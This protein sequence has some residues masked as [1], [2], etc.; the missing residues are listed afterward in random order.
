MRFCGA[1]VHSTDQKSIF[2][3]VRCV[4]SGALMSCLVLSVNIFLQF[5]QFCSVC[6]KGS[7]NCKVMNRDCALN[8]KRGITVRMKFSGNSNSYDEDTERQ[9]FL[10]Y[11]ERMFSSVNPPPIP[12]LVISLL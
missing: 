6:M 11:V 9:Q 5:C 12:S 1:L 10:R 3:V 4:S 8:E 7:L 2:D